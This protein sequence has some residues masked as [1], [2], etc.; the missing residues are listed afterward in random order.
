MILIFGVMCSVMTSSGDESGVQMHPISKTAFFCCGIRADDA[1][2]PGSIYADIYAEDFMTAEGRAVYARFSG[3]PRPNVSN[4]VRARIIHDEIAQRLK[5]NKNLQIVNIGAG[6]DS[7]AYRLA[8]GRWFEFDEPAIIEHKNARLSAGKCP[9]QLQRRPVDFS[10]GELPAALR[11]CDPDIDTLIVIEGVFMYLD[12]AQVDDLLQTLSDRFPR[13]TLICD[14]MNRVFFKR[15]VGK[16]YDQI[17]AL[18][19]EFK[20]IEA[21][22]QNLFLHRGYQQ[23]NLPV[24]IVGRAR[25]FK[26]F[27]IPDVLLR[28]ALRTVR[29]GYRV[30]TFE[31]SR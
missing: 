27:R 30:H 25:D 11:D 19:S 8:G 20:L 24:S 6:F 16:M 7:R 21:R 14:L 15:H 29:D 31:L 22:P 10:S 18:G 26:A 28:T 23:P 13:H 2:S 5:A 3:N 4:V 9:N 17:L 1:R 12:K